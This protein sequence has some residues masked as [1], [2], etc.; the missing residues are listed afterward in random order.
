VSRPLRICVPGGVYHLIARGNNRERIVHDDADR[1][2]FLDI[3]GHVVERFSWL[4]HAYCLMGNH[5]HLVA[6]TPLP[7]LP[8]GMRQLNGLYAQSF[9][10]RHNRCGHVFEARYRS[11]LVEKESYLLAVCRYVVLNPVRAGICLHPQD[12]PWSSYRATAGLEPPEPFLTTDW[13][14]AQF[15]PTRKLAQHRYRTY[16]EA[17]L[18]DELER[19]V[20]GERL[21]EDDFLRESFGYDPPLEEIPRVQVEPL[22]PALEEIFAAA[23]PYPIERAYRRHGYTL[24]Q[25]AKYLGCSYSTISRRLREEEAQAAA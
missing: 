15:A 1:R 2:R 3:L 10:G 8:S 18:A 5:Y 23:H 17:G 11:R 20:R 12:W 14:L 7:N 19:Q 9:N 4:C 13:L 16:V 6:E 21:G 24:N 25:I 22:P